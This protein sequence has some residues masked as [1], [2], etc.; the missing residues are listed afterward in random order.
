M[1]FT[2]IQCFLFVLVFWASIVLNNL[3]H[4]LGHVIVGRLFGLPMH[5]VAIGMKFNTPRP[6]NP[7][8]RLLN[9]DF[10]F[11]TTWLEAY[12]PLPQHLLDR[13]SNKAVISMT[14]AGPL[15][16]TLFTLIWMYFTWTHFFAYGW[17]FGIGVFW[18]W[19]H[20]GNLRPMPGNDGMRIKE[21]L[22]L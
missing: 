1:I 8:F 14:L 20:L 12:A 17:A 10:F 18:I 13:A 21:R 19:G 9:T 3:A 2:L 7:T 6:K 4:E 11:G 22:Y 5:T 16:G 15:A